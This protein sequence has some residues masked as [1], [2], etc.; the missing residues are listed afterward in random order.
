[1]QTLSHLLTRLWQLESRCVTYGK[2][3]DSILCIWTVLANQVGSS[4]SD[5]HTSVS[6]GQ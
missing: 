5:E 6:S 2:N 1:M 3:L 4:G